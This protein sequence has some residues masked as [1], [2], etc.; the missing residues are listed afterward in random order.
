MTNYTARN[1]HFKSIDC[2]S[3]FANHDYHS[4]MSIESF[5]RFENDLFSIDK[6]RRLRLNANFNVERLKQIL[7]ELQVQMTY[8]QVYQQKYVNR[9]REHAFRR[10]VENQV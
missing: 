2:F 8:A 4:R 10:Q 9:H 5:K 6:K 3:F 1:H 7:R